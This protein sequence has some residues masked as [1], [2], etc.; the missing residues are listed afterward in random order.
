MWTTRTNMYAIRARRTNPM[1][2][3]RLQPRINASQTIF[4]SLLPRAQAFRQGYINRGI[5]RSARGRAYDW[6][7]KQRM[8]FHS[9]LNSVT[10]MRVE[11]QTGGFPKLKLLAGTHWRRVGYFFSPLHIF[12][13]ADPAASQTKRILNIAWT[14][15][16]PSQRPSR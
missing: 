1:Y 11:C 3:N 4:N 13:D 16:T 6:A 10:R 5:G 9:T 15:A 8:S 12:D 14:R 7:N 2:P